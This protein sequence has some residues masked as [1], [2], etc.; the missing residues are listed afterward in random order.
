MM[1]GSTLASQLRMKSWRNHWPA[2]WLLLILALVAV[3]R[4]RLLSV[5]LE[6]D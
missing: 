2:L 6:R 3:V 5:P 1:P 4:M